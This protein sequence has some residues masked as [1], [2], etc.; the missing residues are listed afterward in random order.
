[1]R[2]DLRR[3]RSRGPRVA[4]AIGAIAL[5]LVGPALAAAP[6]PVGPAVGARLAAS[7]TQNFTI[8]NYTSSVD[9]TNLSYYEW[10][11]AGYVATQK[12]PL[13]IFLHGLAQTGGELLVET[14]G[15]NTI[16]NASTFGFVLMSVNT[17]T[18]AGFF[19]N[20]PFTG[21][22]EQ[23]VLDALAHELALRSIDASRVFLFGS[24]M[25]S[26]GAWSIAGHH[27]S[28]FRGLGAIAECPE[29][30]AAHYWH[31]LH[32][33]PG[34]NQY[35]TTTGGQGPNT[36]YFQA[37][38]YYQ[39][40]ARF[41]PG[42][43]SHL[44]LYAV[45]GSSDSK[46]PNNPAFFGYLQSNNT[47]LNGTCLVISA[48]NEPANCQTPFANLSAGHRGLYVWR[49]V[50]EAGGIHSFNDLNPRDM[51]RFWTAKIGIGVACATMGGVPH[52]CP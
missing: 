34:F 48:W 21:P 4:A 39:D 33:R 9:G 28:L 52:A 49:F 6:A 29:T 37:E 11:P 10:L 46:C 24:S 20:S 40:S 38:T 31:F 35:L 18:P 22:Q 19:V 25:G 13:A 32:D 14:Q 27:A 8:V 42:N 15:L 45:Q 7:T 51:F 23:D 26:I 41:Y 50:Y 17:R 43:Y 5:L 1:M 44:R 30:Y 36:T 2:R 3:A 12:F 16:A 47:F